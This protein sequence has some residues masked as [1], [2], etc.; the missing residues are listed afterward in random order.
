MP[1]ETPRSAAKCD[2]RGKI[3]SP[4]V[5]YGIR[6]L[7]NESIVHSTILALARIAEKLAVSKSIHEKNK[8]A[9]YTQYLQNIYSE[10]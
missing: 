4:R 9:D 6:W 7:D 3:V 8:L 2:R 1:K 5:F 10:K